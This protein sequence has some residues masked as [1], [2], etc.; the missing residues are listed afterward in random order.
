MF[1]NKT[2]RRQKQRL[3]L[4]QEQLSETNL[5]TQ[6]FISVT[7]EGARPVTWKALTIHSGKI[8]NP[9]EATLDSPIW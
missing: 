7:D 9:R 3:Q 5:T 2:T 8:I 1:L 6:N 4:Q